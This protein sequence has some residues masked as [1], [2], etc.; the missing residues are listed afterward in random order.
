MIAF[1]LNDRWFIF[2]D[3]ALVVNCSEKW[4][5]MGGQHCI[6]SLGEILWDRFPDKVCFGGAPANFACSVAGLADDL[7]RVHLVSAVGRDVLGEKALQ[8]LENHR[9]NVHYVQRPIQ[10]TG[11]VEVKVDEHGI[12]SYQFAE[13]V[14]WDRLEWNPD[15]ELLTKEAD[16]ICFGTLG[17]RCS[18]SAF[19]IQKFVKSTRPDC[20]RVLDLNL[21]SPF[22]NENLVDQSLELANVLKL[23]EDELIFLSQR[24]D[25]TGTTHEILRQ[26]QIQHSFTS[27]VFTCG[28]NGALLLGQDRLIELASWPTNVVDTVGAGDAFTAMFVLGALFEHDLQAVGKAATQYAAFVCGHSGATPGVP[29]EWN[30]NRFFKLN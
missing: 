14:A 4:V 27:V 15:L 2:P 24:F 30:P 7:A 17:Q 18:T 19:T 6:V 23:N 5:W 22:F 26:L 12:A 3:L 13:D 29:A 28:A 21:R 8:A 9:V 16:A 11:T 1:G 10:P 20:L 25:L